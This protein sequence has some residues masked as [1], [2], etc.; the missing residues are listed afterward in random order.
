[1]RRV[2]LLVVVADSLQLVR[3][4]AERVFGADTFTLHLKTTHDL[5]QRIEQLVRSPGARRGVRELSLTRGD[6]SEERYQVSRWACGDMTLDYEL[7]RLDR[8]VGRVVTDCPQLTRLTLTNMAIG[9]LTTALLLSSTRLRRLRL[10]NVSVTREEPFYDDLA[11]AGG[12][13]PQLELDRV[14]LA[15]SLGLIRF[16]DVHTLVLRS[17]YDD[18]WRGGML[19]WGFEPPPIHANVR[20][21]HLQHL[22]AHTVTELLEATSVRRDQ[23]GAADPRS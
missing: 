1:M 16:V 6:V 10:V 2:T 22:E 3:I 5:S 4:S 9:P 18:I 8:L 17:K 14:D 21:L 20:H 11:P 13:I 15:I 19:G 7:R 23:S 12:A